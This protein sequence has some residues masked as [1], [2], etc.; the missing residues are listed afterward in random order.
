MTAAEKQTD[1]Q[2]STG[3]ARYVAWLRANAKNLA[4]IFKRLDS[5]RIQYLIHRYETYRERPVSLYKSLSEEE[6]RA[7]EKLAGTER[8]TKIIIVKLGAFIFA[9]S[10]IT[11]AEASLDLGTAMF[12]RF[13]IHGAWVSVIALNETFLTAATE[14]MLRYVL[15]HE[16]AQGEI[17]TEMAEYNLQNLSPDMRG[18][19]H[20]EARM[21]AIKRSGISEDE[22]EQERQLIIELLGQHP[23]V[24]VHFASAALVTYLIANWAHM[25]QFGAA[26]QTEMERELEVPTASLLERVSRGIELYGVFLR[27]LKQELTMTGAEFGVAVV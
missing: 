3:D 1:E 13:F 7:I 6:E 9:P 20:E 25:Q 11:P 15:E 10:L 26:S 4:E 18:V 22:V 27:A 21:K 14:P 2:R 8:L 19:I 5:Y 24:P 16:L 17:Y 23:V 12:R